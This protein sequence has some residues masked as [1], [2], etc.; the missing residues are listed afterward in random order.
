M[1]IQSGIE[2]AQLM[3]NKKKRI[4]KIGKRMLM[5]SQDRAF[6]AWLELRDE[7]RRKKK[8]MA[9]VLRNAE[10]KAMSKWME[11]VEEKNRLKRL[12]KG[13]KPEG[14]AWRMWLDFIDEKKRSMGMLKRAVHPCNKAWSQWQEW[15]EG[16]ATRRDVLTRYCR[17]P[18]PTTGSN[19]P[20]W[21]VCKRQWARWM[22]AEAEQGRAKTAAAA[23]AR[24]QRREER[25]LRAQTRRAVAA[26][27]RADQARRRLERERAATEAAEAKR[28]AR[29]ER[30]ARE[31]ERQR[32][33]ELQREA[34]RVA[35]TPAADGGSPPAERPERNLRKV[36][37]GTG[38]RQKLPV[39]PESRLDHHW[40]HDTI[41]RRDYTG[42]RPGGA[43]GSSGSSR[44]R[45]WY[46]SGRCGSTGCAGPQYKR[47]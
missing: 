5:L 23:A 17:D 18:N 29:E 8:A 25:D 35:R 32:M 45:E 24:A 38:G 39:L 15:W 46:G 2:H 13:S 6:V 47:R 3:G 44:S 1:Q 26:A 20:V 33:A 12:F 42:P 14:R 4:K 10:W 34:K 40:H 43:E 19:D 28:V 27:R 41:R 21:V 31:L 7:E 16:D 22:E 11:M 36:R 9:K 37:R 30:R